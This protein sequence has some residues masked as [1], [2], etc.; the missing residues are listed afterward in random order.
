MPEGAT[1]ELPFFNVN[2]MCGASDVKRQTSGFTSGG[3]D[4]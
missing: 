2:V 3:P 4:V 1:W